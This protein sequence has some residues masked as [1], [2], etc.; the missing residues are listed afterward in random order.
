MAVTY[1]LIARYNNRRGEYVAGTYHSQR[2]QH[3]E[4]ARAAARA[5]W[6]LQAQRG[7]TGYV[8]FTADN[9]QTYQRETFRAG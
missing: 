8:T 9:G 3:I 1:Q 6:Q 2:C 5:R 7:A 4:A